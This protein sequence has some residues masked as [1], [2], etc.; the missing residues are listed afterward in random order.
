MNKSIYFLFVLFSI[1]FSNLFGQGFERYK[2]LI[3]TTIASQ[4]LGFEKKISITVPIEW[5]KDDERKFPLIVVFDKQNKRS[6]NYILN[7][8]DYLTSNEQMP[9]AIIVSVESEQKYR[10]LETQYKISSEKGLAE[11]NEKFL[12]EELIPFAENE[13]KAASFRLFIGHS[14]Y[15]YFTSSLLCSKTNELNAVISISPFFE[16]KNINLVDSIQT[17]ASQKFSSRKYYRFGIGNDFPKDFF[18]MDSVVK[19]FTNPTLDAKGFFFE[20]AAHNVTPGLTIAVSLYEIFENWSKTQS[21]YISNDQKDLKIINSLEEEIIANYGSRL[22]FSL[23]ILNG[24]GWYF[25]NEKE[26]EKAI[27]AWQLLMKYYPNFS[28][29]YL[30]IMYAQVQLNEDISKTIKKFNLSLAKSNMYS[31]KEKNE[32]VEEVENL[33]Q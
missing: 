11:E 12:F 25:Y 1:C 33:E 32:L 23:G 9:S 3:D 5:Q 8:I 26:Y 17:L 28:E 13:Y 14:R 27:E 22:E 15:G 30:Y 19:K 7:T 18:K 21:K 2:Q 4:Y 24:K 31:K 16:Q 29:G 6:H 20:E 10:F